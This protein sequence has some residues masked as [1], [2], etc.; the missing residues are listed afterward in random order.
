MNNLKLYNTANRKVTDF[1]PVDNGNIKIYAC[2][3]DI[4]TS[5]DINIHIKKKQEK[6]KIQEI[7]EKSKQNEINN[8]I[9]I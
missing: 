3:N 1:E 9:K 2:K 8:L 4:K 5:S 7:D 6:N